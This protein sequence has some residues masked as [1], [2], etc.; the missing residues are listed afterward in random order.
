MRGRNFGWKALWDSNPDWLR[1]RYDSQRRSGTQV[2]PPCLGMVRVVPRPWVLHLGIRLT[3]EKTIWKKNLSQGSQLWTIS[4]I[5][6]YFLFGLPLGV[7][8]LHAGTSS[9]VNFC[10]TYD[11]TENAVYIPQLLSLCWNWLGAMWGVAASY[12]R[13]AL[14]LGGGS[15]GALTE[16]Q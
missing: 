13:C 12:F 14:N 16:H 9:T 2:R 1:L 4:T 8:T 11:Y 15:H 10:W 7:S 3:T 5:P 6:I